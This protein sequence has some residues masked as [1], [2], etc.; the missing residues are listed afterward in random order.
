MSLKLRVESDTGT[1]YDCH[2]ASRW[3]PD[4]DSK[5]FC[6]LL[7]DRQL[8]QVI[9]RLTG[10][11]VEPLLTIASDEGIY[12]TETHEYESFEEYQEAKWQPLEQLR[13]CIQHIIVVLDQRP[14]IYKELENLRGTLGV[15]SFNGHLFTD[16]YFIGGGFR[17]ELTDLLDILED[18]RTRGTQS[19]RLLAV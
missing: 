5:L 3:F 19:V 1:I 4:S 15:E 8:I 13:Q 9:A 7:L 2:I 12:P 6:E 17:Q 18:A 11:D 16:P 10:V 14:T